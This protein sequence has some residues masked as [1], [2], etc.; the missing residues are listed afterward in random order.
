MARPPN[1]ATSTHDAIREI[2][3][4]GGFLGRKGYKV[5]VKINHRKK[6]VNPLTTKFQVGR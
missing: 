1:I 6:A 4:Q 2:A 5:P 3:M